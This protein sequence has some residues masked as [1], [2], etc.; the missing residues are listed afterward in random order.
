M[1]VVL[2][3]ATMHDLGFLYG[4]T[5]QNHCEI[6]VQ[7]LPHYLKKIGVSYS[8]TIVRHIA[9]CIATH[10]GSMFKLEPQTLEAKVV[11]DADL[12]EKFGPIGVYQLIRT[13]V[14]FEKGIEDTI[15]K[16]KRNS[17]PDLHMETKTDAK[18]VT[19]RSR[20]YIKDFAKALDNA[21]KPYR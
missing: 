9:D 1:Q 2:P 14:E 20:K 7:N 12:L 3:A 6:G 18:L 16:L 11:C 8:P 15:I 13:W 5:G 10:K 21:F 4:A 19:Q 17:L